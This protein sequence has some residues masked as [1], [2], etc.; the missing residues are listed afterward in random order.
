MIY[1]LKG[2]LPWQGIKAKTRRHK[3]E[4]IRD[5]K[6]KITMQE[7]CEGLPEEFTTYMLYIRNL[8][9]E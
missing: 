5:K 8:A 9:F 4:Q 2:R 7:L 6:A 3:E 1:F